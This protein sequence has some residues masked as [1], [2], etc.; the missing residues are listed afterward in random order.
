MNM[1]R[2]PVNEDWRV[3]CMNHSG[4]CLDFLLTKIGVSS[5]VKGSLRNMS[6]LPANEDWRVQCRDHS[7]P[8]LDFLLTKIGVSSAGIT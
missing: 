3:Q 2:L 7:G 5:T 4:T 1:S 6:R 8:F